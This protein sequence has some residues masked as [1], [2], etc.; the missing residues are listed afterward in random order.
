MGP[1]D[2]YTSNPGQNGRSDHVLL[3]LPDGYGPATHNIILADLYA[4]AG[5]RTILPDYF[6][7]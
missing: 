3:L 4:Q 1:V 2:V 5:Y 7:G 6:E